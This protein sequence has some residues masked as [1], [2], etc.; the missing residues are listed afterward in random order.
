MLEIYTRFYRSIRVGEIQ[1]E[2]GWMAQEKLPGGG[3]AQL[4]P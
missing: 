4:W 3:D 1:G 2:E